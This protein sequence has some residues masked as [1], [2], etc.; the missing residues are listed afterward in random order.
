MPLILTVQLITHY[1][2]HLAWNGLRCTWPIIDCSCCFDIWTYNVVWAMNYF[3]YLSGWPFIL[4]VIDQFGVDRTNPLKGSVV[5]VGHHHVFDFFD[6]SSTGKSQLLE[7]SK[8]TPTSACLKPQKRGI[9]YICVML[10]FT[11]FQDLPLQ[12]RSAMTWL[13]WMVSRQIER[14]VLLVRALCSH[15]TQLTSC[16]L[17][18]PLHLWS[19]KGAKAKEKKEGRRLQ[20]RTLF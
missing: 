5:T 16:C 11:K 12:P 2:S 10:H 6:L 7:V 1:S 3:T 13:R 15:S 14:I 19:S 17:A 20:W 8:F 9:R 18:V 4:K